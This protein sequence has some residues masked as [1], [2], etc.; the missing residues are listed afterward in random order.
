MS[1]NRRQIVAGSLASGLFALDARGQAVTT[2]RLTFVHT[3]D[4]YKMSEEEGRG[5]LARLAAVVKAE[6]ARNPNTF[7]T[8]GGDTLSPNLMSGF[9]QGEHMFAMFNALGLDAFAPGNHEFDFGVD[10]YRKRIGEARFPVLAANLREADGAMLAR[11]RDTMTVERDGVKIGFVGAILETTPILSSPGALTFA[12]LLDTVIAKAGELRREGADFVVALVH[13]DKPTGLRLFASRAAD[14]VLMGHTHDLHIDYDGR[15]ALV[16]SA[17]D[18]IFVVVT[19]V[20]LTIAGAG[21]ERRVAWRA[22]FRIID[23]ADVTPDPEMRAMVAG[24]EAELSKELDVAVAT[25]AAPLESATGLVRGGETAIGNF[26][27]D[28]LRAQNDSEVAILNGG[29]IRGNRRY[30]VG[31]QLTRR[32]ILT[33][34]PFGNKSAVTRVTGKTL[35][36][37]IENGLATVDAPSGRFPQVSGLEVVVDRSAPRGERVVSMQVNG[38]PLDADRI[39]R[40]AVLDFMLRGGDGYG[41]LRDPNATDDTGDRLIANDVMVYARKL[42]AIAAKVEG[43]MVFR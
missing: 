27:A 12:P 2:A 20:T 35:R 29:G 37:A 21:A 1:F 10:V 11:H 23:S 24:Y 3:N 31:H 40:V 15:S 6:R 8:H 13:C 14:L 33:E 4:V 34:L 41:A 5:G 36:E 19:D 28:A 25:L 17:Q 32:D 16:E 22:N 9:D 30:P 26:F 43:R 39:Y 38:A 18:A 42:G 7:F